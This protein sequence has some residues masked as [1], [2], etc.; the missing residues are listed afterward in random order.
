M[1]NDMNLKDI[2]TG[3]LHFTE[4]A[5]RNGSVTVRFGNSFTLD[6]SPGQARDLADSLNFFARKATPITFGCTCETPA[7]VE[8]PDGSFSCTECGGIT[9]PAQTTIPAS[10]EEELVEMA[11]RMDPRDAM[12]A[13]DKLLTLA[14]MISRSALPAH[15]SA[16]DRPDLVLAFR[17]AIR[18]VSM[19]REEPPGGWDHS[20]DGDRAEDEALKVLFHEEA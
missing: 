12:T 1:S 18:S 9:S 19:E 7:P 11:K 20:F 4:I 8:E 16:S 17:S 10:R 3:A 6:I 13:Q 14:R 15:A 2:D 5:E